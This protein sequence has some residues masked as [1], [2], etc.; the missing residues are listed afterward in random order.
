MTDRTL[1]WLNANAMRRYPFADDTALGFPDDVILDAGVT[2]TG[3]ADTSAPFKLVQIVAYPGV[4]GLLFTFASGSLSFSVEVPGAAAFPYRVQGL[5][6]G[7]RYSVCFGEGC[8][9]LMSA[10]GD[11]VVCDAPLLP[12]LVARTAG[13]RVDS[14][15]AGGVTVTGAVAV[16]P[17]YNCLP[18]ITASGLSL[19][20]A[21]GAGAGRTCATAAGV[22]SCT[23]ALRRINGVPPTADGDFIITVT[24]AGIRA[25]AVNHELIVSDTAKEKAGDC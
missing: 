1:E 3:D 6:D 10:D 20:A 19:T 7:L 12:A 11:N 17:G 9:G 23:E 2:V 13:Q 16:V 21:P 22:V 24:G 8:V 5:A 15:T 25:D 4:A 14:I 18:T